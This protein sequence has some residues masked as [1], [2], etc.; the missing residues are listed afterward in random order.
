MASD[1]AHSQA[2][3]FGGQGSNGAINDTWVWDGL[4]WTKKTPVT[5]PPGLIDYRMEYDA[6]RGQIVLV[7]SDNFANGQL[8]QTWV[9]DGTNWA[10][11]S[12]TSSPSTRESFSMAYDS[13][14]HQLVLFGG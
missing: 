7:G 5:N 12:P 2:V 1:S 9:W 10:K 8:L 13:M 6:T 11:K 4:T 3:L 14:R